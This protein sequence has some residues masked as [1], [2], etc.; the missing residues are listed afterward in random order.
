[1]ILLYAKSV[2]SLA[3]GIAFNFSIPIGRCFVL[4]IYTSSLAYWIKARFEWNLRKV[5]KRFKYRTVQ[6]LVHT[7]WNVIEDTSTQYRHSKQDFSLSL[8]SSSAFKHNWCLTKNLSI[9]EWISE[10]VSLDPILQK[11]RLGLIL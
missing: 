8:A 4:R 11:G 2:A 6:L 1:M 5:K 3:W 9:S 7:Q 10:N